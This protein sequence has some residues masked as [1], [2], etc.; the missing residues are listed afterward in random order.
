MHYDIGTNNIYFSDIIGR[1]I[2]RFDLNEYQ[3][4]PANIENNISPS[5][6]I[7][8]EGYAD[9]YIVSDSHTVTII[10]W[11]GK[12]PIAKVRQQTFTVETDE[13]Y[14][15]NVWNIAKISPSGQYVGG[16]FRKEICSSTPGD[17]AGL[18][19][20]TPEHGVKLLA[21]NFKVA[22]GLDWNVE[23]ELFYLV[24]SCNFVINEYKWDRKTGNLRKLYCT[25]GEQICINNVNQAKF[26]MF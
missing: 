14:A 20:Y 12:D 15:T 24:D 16:T 1:M 18:Y 26:S 21:N 6:I 5:Y 23:K 11:N 4:Y 19:Q 9:R 25:I 2:H 10:D 7:P 22:G 8:L 17:I 3:D 13:K